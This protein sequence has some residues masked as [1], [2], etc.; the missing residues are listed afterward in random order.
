MDGTLW[1]TVKAASHKFSYLLTY[2]QAR[3]EIQQPL[4][5]WSNWR[6]SESFTLETDVYVR[7]Y[8]LLGV[9]ETWFKVTWCHL[10]GH[11]DTLIYLQ[12]A[13]IKAFLNSNMLC[14]KAMV[15]TDLCITNKYMTVRWCIHMHC[16]V[17]CQQ[18]LGLF[19]VDL[20]IHSCISACI[21]IYSFQ[22]NNQT[23]ITYIAKI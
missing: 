15:N 11:F 8:T 4:A 5:E 3:P 23:I 14:M 16:M 12:N 19:L 9:I 7:R 13:Q 20:L 6:G 21:E 10:D 1:L 18:C 2:F 22:W 17:V